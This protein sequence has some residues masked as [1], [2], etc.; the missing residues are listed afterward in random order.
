[1]CLTKSTLTMAHLAAPKAQVA[2]DRAI[3]QWLLQTGFDQLITWSIGTGHLEEFQKD[4]V[5]CVYR[6]PQAI[7]IHPNLRDIEVKSDT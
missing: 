3:G 6:A 5:N 4:N 1:M 7:P 2:T